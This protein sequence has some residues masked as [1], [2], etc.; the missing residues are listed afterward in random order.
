ME[1]D[2]QTIKALSAD[3]R[4]NILKMLKENRRIAAD[5]SKEI[6]LAPST[7]NEHLK[8]MEN[9]GLVRKNDTGHKWIYYDITEKGKSMVTPKMPISIILTLSLGIG[10]ALFGGAGFFAENMLY[11]TGDAAAQAV[12]KAAE[13]T[14]AS[15]AAQSA[16]S[17]AAAPA[18]NWLP[19][20]I[21]A[22]GLVLVV[23]GFIKMRRK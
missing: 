4:V 2:K 19:L 7:V 17:L 6:G 20:L 10:L 22:I 18:T 12:Q 21:L 3:A 13:I 23:Y 11:S 9:A 5:I 15:G 16:G 1:I 8:M 14:S